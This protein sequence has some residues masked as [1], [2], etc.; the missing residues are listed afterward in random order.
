[1]MVT[2]KMSKTAAGAKSPKVVPKPAKPA[3]KSTK[4]V[5][6]TVTAKAVAKSSAKSSAKK[7]VSAV[8]SVVAKNLLGKKT[9]VNVKSQSVK[10]QS[11]KD[12]GK[13]AKKIDA[14]NAEKMLTVKAAQAKKLEPVKLV[15]AKTAPVVKDAP[16]KA[17]LKNK[18]MLPLKAAVAKLTPKSATKAVE[19]KKIA[20]KSPAQKSKT[21]PDAKNTVS[22]VAEK[23]SLVNPDD[24]ASVKPVM[25]TVKSESKAKALSVSKKKETKKTE[26]KKEKLIKS[27]AEQK[28]IVVRPVAIGKTA[29]MKPHSPVPSTPPKGSSPVS[30]DM[31]DEAVLS[32]PSKESIKAAKAEKIIKAKALKNS[33]DS[34]ANFKPYEAGS[35]EE[36]MNAEQLAHFRALLNRW[37]QELM[38]EVDRTVHHMQDESAN[39]PD[40]ADRATQEEEFTFELRTRDR[41]RKLIKKIDQALEALD[42]N[43]YGYCESCG[44]EIGIRR[45][46]AR[47]TATLCI[48]CKTLDEIKEKQLRGS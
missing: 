3:A 35:D 27:Q 21:K 14:G 39:L 23:S 17:S 4:A 24:K 25:Q 5:K 38:E 36:Y 10:K 32:P 44:V 1:M 37:K 6:A 47:P 13:S 45:L 40:P 19:T 12:V 9:A 18:L 15:T 7:P 28:S 20:L 29:V 2:K 43:D 42:D 41:E 26:I 16:V 22:A 11:V 31:T 33:G 8:N 30:I 46:E 48:D 34:P